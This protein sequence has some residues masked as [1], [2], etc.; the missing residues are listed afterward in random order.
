MRVPTQTLP[1][2][3]AVMEH[4][5]YIDWS[6]VFVGAVVATALSWLLLTFGSAVGLLALSPYTV[7]SGTAT[8]VTMGAAIWFALT[9]IYAIGMG[10][11]V[12][13]RLR[14]REGDGDENE[15]RFR[16]GITGLTVWALAIIL[17]LLVAGMAAGVAARGGAAAVGAA[18]VPRRGRSI[19]RTRSISCF[20]RRPLRTDSPPRRLPRPSRSR[21]PSVRRS[22]V[23]SSTPWRR[24]RSPTPTSNI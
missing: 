18:T 1:G 16:D 6:A 17:G 12:A 8:T 5:S 3:V 2:D 11:Y 14:P 15:V 4:A 23:S 21:T 19:Q 22:A 24:D 9:Q 13:A 20:G 7:T 10:A